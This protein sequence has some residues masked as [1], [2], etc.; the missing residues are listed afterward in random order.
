MTE[1]TPPQANPYAP[2]QARVDDVP[3]VSAGPVLASRGVRFGG[4]LIDSLLLV[5]LVL[6][7]L[8]FLG[9]MT[10]GPSVLETLRNGVFGF[11]VFVLVNGTWLAQR[12]Q[13]VGKRIVGTRIVRSDGSSVT[14]GRLLG[15]RYGLGWAL[16]L[17]PVLGQLYGLVD[18]LLI[19]RAS[20]QCLHDNFADTIVIK[21]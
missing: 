19:F 2:P 10:Q 20:R 3:D 14:F 13:T 6:P 5:M 8:Y 18:S 11:V 1:P 21:T 12:G 7:P 17:I 15:L 9:W 4:A 16:T